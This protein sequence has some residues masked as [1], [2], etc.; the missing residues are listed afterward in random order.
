[1]RVPRVGELQIKRG[2][3]GVIFKQELAEQTLGKTAKQYELTLF[4]TNN[5]LMNERLHEVDRNKR[6]PEQPPGAK[7]IRSAKPPRPSD[8]R[9]AVQKLDIGK[10]ADN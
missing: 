7:S 4:Q 8:V 2:I 3:A 10:L 9:N 5:N 6:G 1:M